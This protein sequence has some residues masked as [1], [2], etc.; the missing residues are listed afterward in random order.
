MTAAANPSQ[1]QRAFSLRFAAVLGG[2]AL[3]ALGSWASVPMIPVPTTLQTL[4]LFVIAGLAGPGLTFGA[5]AV[6]LVLAAFGA[7]ML[8]GF[9]G[10]WQA[11]TGPTAGFLLAFAAVGPLAAWA[12]PKT[13]GGDLFAVFLVG[14]SLVLLIGWAWLAVNVG[15]Q[16]AFL[17]GVQPFFFAAIAKSAAATVIVMLAK[18]RF[19]RVVSRP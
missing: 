10:G 7:P 6:W 5:L 19:P 14:H 9:H 4:A 13:K 17:A 12:V 3:L 18:A 16:Q 11:L 1:I 15:P 2:A 8:A